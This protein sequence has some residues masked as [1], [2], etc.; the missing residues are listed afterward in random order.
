MNT[1]W[2]LVRFKGQSSMKMVRIPVW[3]WSGFLTIS[4]ATPIYAQSPVPSRPQ[5]TTT[6]GAIPAENVTR[7]PTALEKEIL[8]SMERL[9]TA[10]N[11]SDIDGLLNSFLKEGELIDDAGNVYSGHDQIRELAKAYFEKYPGAQTAAELESVRSAGGIVFADGKRTISTK[12]GKSVALI[13]FSSV[14]Q[15]TD[16]GFRLASIRDFAEPVL[17]TPNE[18]LQGISWLV[19]DWINEGADAR[20]HIKYQWSEDNNFIL[21]TIAMHADG[22]MTTSSSQRIGWDPILG[23]YRSWVFDRDGGYGEGVW[24]EAEDG[25]S[26]QSSAVTP[27]GG[28]GSATM[29]II[30]QSFDRFTIRGSNRTVNGQSEPDYEIV[31]VKKPATAK[32]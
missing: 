4:I 7:E 13:R 15:K 26:I 31:I 16:Q 8:G 23:S 25:W 30:P 32:N 2:L 20:V 10:F 29:K 1:Q 27:E 22:K 24:S 11:K 18:A 28:K 17:P 9:L 6:N 19:G 5:L 12:D 3:L 21:G 14:W